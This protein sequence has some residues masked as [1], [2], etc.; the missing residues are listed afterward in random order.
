[1]AQKTL[2][3]V[4]ISTGSAFFL[5]QENYVFLADCTLITPL[6]LTLAVVAARFGQG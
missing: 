2:V 6:A 1:M 5:V 3:R 4:V